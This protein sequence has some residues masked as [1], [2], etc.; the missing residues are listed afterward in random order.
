M[1][2]WVYEAFPDERQNAYSIPGGKC[3]DSNKRNTSTW[4][5]AGSQKVRLHLFQPLFQGRI[6]I[7][8]P[9]PDFYLSYSEKL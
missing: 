5:C 2:L 7:M 8:C 6:S 9:S 3:S 1:K 4:I